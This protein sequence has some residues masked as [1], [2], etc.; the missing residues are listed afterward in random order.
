MSFAD[1]YLGRQ[2]GIQPNIAHPPSS[3]LGFIV[4]I[5]V[6][7]EPDLD[8]ALESL[9]KTQRPIKDTEVI[10][11]VN[12]SLHSDDTIKAIN[13]ETTQKT[14]KWI[15]D[16]VDPSL[17]FFIIEAP[18]LAEKY[19]GAG[20]AR[21]IGMDEAIIRYANIANPHGFILSFDADSTCDPDYF[22]A[23]QHA[24]DADTELQGFDIYFEHP[25]AGNEYPDEIYRSVTEYELHLRYINQFMRYTG[26]PF[27][28]HTVGSCFGVRADIYAAQGG[29]NK[30]KGG[31]D[32]YF[33]HKVIPLGHFI[34]ICETRV[35]PSPRESFRV[36]FGTGPAI[37]KRIMQGS[38][39]KTYAPQCFTDLKTLFEMI[40][41]CFKS[42]DRIETV[43]QSVPEA[44]KEFLT[45]NNIIES[46]TEINANTGHLASF[47]NRF[48]RWYDAFRIVKYLNFASSQF[49]PKIKVTEAARVLLELKGIRNDSEDAMGLLIQFRKTERSVNHQ[50]L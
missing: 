40:P 16:H 9:W 49:Y 23:I 43:L 28:H 31:E 11:V 48:Y 21:K 34:D 6:Y 5:P 12:S 18:G 36:P 8:K 50:Q 24:I 19:A 3:N 30:K 47:I 4:V 46:L 27:A 14:Q 2:K 44:L 25:V 1:S 10:M 13:L 35:I 37:T 29:M 42:P 38:E 26:F 33:L 20:M 17:R 41:G 45:V 32:F 22:T 39:M 7:C 15:S